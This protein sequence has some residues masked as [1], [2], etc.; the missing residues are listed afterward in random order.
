MGGVWGE[1]DKDGGNYGG[2]FRRNVAINVI[3]HSGVR[4]PGDLTHFRPTKFIRGA[5]NKLPKFDTG[6]LDLHS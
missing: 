2:A 4:I 3:R 1:G 6:A 5:T